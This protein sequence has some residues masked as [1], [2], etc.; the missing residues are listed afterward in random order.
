MFFVH[1]LTAVESGALLAMACDHA[2]AIGRPLHYPILVT[3]ARVGYAS[4]AL[5]LKAVVVVPF[6]LL[7][8]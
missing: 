2:V 6:P 5:A 3:K 7:V 1:V 4:L 8:A